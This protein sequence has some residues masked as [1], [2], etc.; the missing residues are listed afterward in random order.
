LKVSPNPFR[1][2]ALVEFIAPVSGSI[3]LKTYSTD[4]RLVASQAQ[5]AVIGQRM[6]FKLDGTK[7]A[8]GTY[9]LQVVTPV[10]VYAR[11]TAVLK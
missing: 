3:Q 5:T 4:G 7:L 9:L 1:G 11:K 10:G 8:N 6:S 2:Q